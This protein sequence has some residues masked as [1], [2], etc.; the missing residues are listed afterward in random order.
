LSPW[1]SPQAYL[2]LAETAAGDPARFWSPPV[3][4]RLRQIKAAVDPQDM[5][6]ANHS[7]PPAGR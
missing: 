7:V 5:I 6:R 2:N 3:Y 1:A 4:E